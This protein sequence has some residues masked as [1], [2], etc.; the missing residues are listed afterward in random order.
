M[1]NPFRKKSVDEVRRENADLKKELAA[2]REWAEI[3]E[4]NL[5]LKEEKARLAKRDGGFH[6][7]SEGFL[8]GVDAILGNEKPKRKRGR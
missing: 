7:D 6:F 2:S 3:H 5:K 8:G 4:E 1:E